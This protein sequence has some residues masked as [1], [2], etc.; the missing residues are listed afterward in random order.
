MNTTWKTSADESI[1]ENLTSYQQAYWKNPEHY[2][3]LQRAKYQRYPEKIKGWTK[4]WQMEHPE[5]WRT[6]SR[7]NSKIWYW[8]NKKHDTEKVRL[9]E[10]AKKEAMKTFA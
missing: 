2:R 4:K 8:K 7:F 1:N 9:L 6:L 10:R 5:H 3:A